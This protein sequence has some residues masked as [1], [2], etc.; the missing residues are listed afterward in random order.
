MGRRVIGLS[1]DVTAHSDI[2]LITAE[3]ARK[4]GMSRDDLPDTNATIVKVCTEQAVKQ[5]PNA[6]HIVFLIP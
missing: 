2:I 1:Y 3:I 4:P 5:S 6:I